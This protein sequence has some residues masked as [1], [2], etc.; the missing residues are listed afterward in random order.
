MRCPRVDR[1]D[2]PNVKQ[3]AARAA[4]QELD[5]EPTVADRAVLPDQL[6]IRG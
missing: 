6:Y 5:L 4:L 3:N 2:Q 1:Q